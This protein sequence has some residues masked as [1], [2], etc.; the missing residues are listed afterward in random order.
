MCRQ[1]RYQRVLIWLQ[2]LIAI[3]LVAQSARMVFHNDWRDD[4]RQGDQYFATGQYYTALQTYTTLAD[5]VDHAE[6]ALR[7]GIIRAIRGEYD[8]A[9]YALWQALHGRLAPD[10]R[11]LAV[12]Y[13]GYVLDR[14]DQAQRARQVWSWLPSHTW[15]AGYAHVL[16]AEWALYHG[17]YA[18]AELDYRAALDQFL[19]ADWHSLVIYRLALLQAATN[20][21]A[22]QTLL[23]A[24]HQPPS[25]PMTRLAFFL[26]PL[27]AYNDHDVQQLH[28]VLQA[29][30]DLRPQLLGQF[31][32]DHN[33]FALAEAQF[34]AIAAD[35][36][37]ARAAAAYAAYTR[38]R[39]GDRD[40]SLKQ[41]QSL[42]AAHPNDPRARTLLALV[43]LN[44][45]NADAARIQI[46]T[47][48][49]L[50][51]TNPDTH[52]AWAHWYTA[53]SDYVN[54]SQEYQRA[55]EQAQPEQR[56][57][58]ALLVARFH[59]H[60]TYEICTYGLPAAELAIETLDAHEEAW[61]TL[62]ASRYYCADFQGA[63]EAAQQA[64]QY[65][66]RAD[67][68]FYLG[69][70]LNATGERA[71]AQIALTHAADLAPAS[72][73]RERAEDRLNWWY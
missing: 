31:Y 39:A 73:W 54:A 11:D 42:V 40:Q 2:V 8:Q 46:D 23:A 27:L 61:T 13:Q 6:I 5:Q 20:P 12:L 28:T 63:I 72:I 4:L 49:A 37:H 35:S 36:P 56:G 70:A 22:A 21:P 10:A 29:D 45:A 3:P 47:I 60:T 67:A 50:A 52:L 59:L 68:A 9:E 1:R 15:F 17:D 55:L 48:T 57:K 34:A 66:A 53:Q 18:A 69:L 58:Y 7:I 33:L 44:Q 30:P 38:W 16:Q 65:N 71:A 32:L 14:R 43:Y 19:L 62:A 26:K 64:L 24:L 25:V 51:P 41:L